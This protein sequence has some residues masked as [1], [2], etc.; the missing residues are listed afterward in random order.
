MRYQRRE[1]MRLFKVE[2]Y[3]GDP[4]DPKTKTLK[5]TIVAW[6]AM[7]A[8]RR[9]GNKR[10]VSQPVASHHVTHPKHEDGP[11]YKIDS[12]AGPTDETEVKPSILTKPSTSD[13]DK[14]ISET[15]RLRKRKAKS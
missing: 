5:E 15:K 1:L 14:K 3:D 11:I 6:N 10:L 7:D 8:I 9:C 2:V 13:F 4:D 12:T